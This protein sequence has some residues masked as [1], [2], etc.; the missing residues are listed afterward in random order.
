M[1]IFSSVFRDISRHV[2]EAQ[3]KIF[4][5]RKVQRNDMYMYVKQAYKIYEYKIHRDMIIKRHKENKGDT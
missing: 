2:R 5:S 1:K 3:F 4:S